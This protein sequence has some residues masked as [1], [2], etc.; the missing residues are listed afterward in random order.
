MQ[1]QKLSAVVA[2]G[3]AVQSHARFLLYNPPIWGVWME[4]TSQK[5]PEAS[6]LRPGLHKER[7]AFYSAFY[8]AIKSRSL[9]GFAI[10]SLCLRSALQDPGAKSTNRRSDRKSS[11]ERTIMIPPLT[12]SSA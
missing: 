4:A 9:A 3:L 5:I 8:G 6:D 1:L 11:A 10:C 7:R 2:R 12:T